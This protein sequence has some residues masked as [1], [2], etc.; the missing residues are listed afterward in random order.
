MAFTEIV[1]LERHA[2]DDIVDESIQSVDKKARLVGKIGLGILH[3]IEVHLQGHE[4]LLPA[5]NCE[6]GE[7][8][9]VVEV[10]ADFQQARQIGRALE[11]H[12]GL[13]LVCSKTF[14]FLVRPLKKERTKSPTQCGTLDKGRMLGVTYFAAISHVLQDT[15]CVFQTEVVFFSLLHQDKDGYLA[16]AIGHQGWRGI[17]YS[18]DAVIWLKVSN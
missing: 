16:L 8:K 2:I 3:D 10:V 12:A 14:A 11:I 18:N 5:S 13:E 4:F 1:A 17:C 15:G 6:F 7:A 9:L